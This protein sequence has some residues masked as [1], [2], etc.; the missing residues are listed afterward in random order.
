MKKVLLLIIATASIAVAS[1]QIQF[2][3]KA[4][5]NLASVMQSGSDNTD[6]LKSKSGF[7]GGALV[8]IPVSGSF[9]VQPEIVY[10]GQGTDV[11]SNGS[12]GSVNFN[13]LN[14]PVLAKYQSESGLFGETGP[15]VGFLLSANVSSQ[16]SSVSIK[17]QSQ[18]VDFS[19]AFGLGYKLH[20][21][22]LGFD[23]RYN[24][25]LTNMIKN[26]SNESWKNSVF[27]IG[28]FYMFNTGK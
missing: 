5:Y 14:I 28:V 1:A 8:L 23:V 11:S 12:S 26:S 2:G 6:G 9:F 27:Q 20:D 3:V 25:G 4:N 21:M 18:S 19:W 7:S 10:S 16:G 13:Y 22:G 17:D 24:L 15:Q